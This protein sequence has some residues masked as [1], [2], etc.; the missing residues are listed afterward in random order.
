M[1]LLARLAALLLFA[2]AVSASAQ[3]L[4]EQYVRIYNLIQQ[5]DYFRDAAQPAS[6]LERYQQAQELLTKL[7]ASYPNWNEVVVKFRLRYLGDQ[8]KPLQEQVAAMQQ[9]KKEPVSVIKTEVTP[10]VVPSDAPA[11]LRR[12]IEQLQSDV[13]R[14][15][16]DKLTLESK[17]REA[18]SAQPAATDPRRLAAAEEQV[19]ILQKENE[20]LKVTLKQERDKLAKAGNP[21]EVDKLRVAL[22][23]A[24]S[25]LAEQAEVIAK[26]RL[27]KEALQTR[28]QQLV[29]NPAE[30]A[31][32]AENEKLKLQVADLTAKAQ[33]ADE[34]SAQVD[35]ARKAMQDAINQMDKLAKEKSELEQRVKA[36]AS[37]PTEPASAPIN[38]AAAK[39]AE[40]NT[41]LTARLKSV[42][43]ELAEAKK[44]V[45]DAANSVEK[46]QQER[47]TLMAKVTELEAAA[48][49]AALVAAGPKDAADMINRD[50]LTNQITV[51]RA[52]LEVLEARQ[53]PYTPEELAL[54][55]KP[56][57]NPATVQT[58]AGKASVKVLPSGAA[59][60]VAQAEK[61][62]KDRRLDE[63]ESL[64]GQALKLDEKNPYIL[65]N[66]AAI[67]SELNR[68]PEAEANLTKALA[69]VPTDAY[70]L[71][72]MG[73]VKF[74][75]GKFDDALDVLGR[76]AQVEPNNAEIQNYLGI[77]L[78][79]KGLR[80]P[81]ETALRKAVQL[82]PGYG[83][84][85]HNLAVTYA[86]SQPPSLELARWHYQKAIDSGHPRNPDLENL[87]NAK[88]AQK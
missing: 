53:I 12:M 72:L 35:S 15:Q 80:G 45:V 46:L 73:I 56:D 47:T 34:L 17:L 5:G 6:A 49:N 44:L 14:L 64:Y 48:K 50:R 86:M 37:T 31:L 69:E 70:S 26:L 30:Q 55:K 51:L 61:A 8:I 38:L 57:V 19:R 82:A 41:L 59:P 16:G 9:P 62:F 25:K 75:Q 52:R 65:A 71:T 29:N 60:L 77:T 84:A 4:D 39:A 67:Q 27:E 13:S 10:V 24:N 78:S 54:F 42:E 87:L 85:H 81:A 22:A 1:K 28:I 63:A 11:D 58:N 20:I 18:L 83:S 21:E 23:E 79:Q 36:M 68:L 66:I 40:E 88:A 32:K 7:Q 43:A 33:R 3:T 76:A 2:V 74:R